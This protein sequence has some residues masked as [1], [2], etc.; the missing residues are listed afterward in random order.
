MSELNPGQKAAVELCECGCGKPAPITKRNNRKLG[1]I[2]GKPVNFIVG[3]NLKAF[4][5]KK[6]I[7][8]M[9]DDLGSPMDI[10]GYLSA[11]EKLDSNTTL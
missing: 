5:G 1:H 9:V 8:G 7:D 10:S 2:K 6:V 4:K 11:T 3:H